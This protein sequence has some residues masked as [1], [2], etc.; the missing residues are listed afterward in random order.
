MI[1]NIIKKAL[2]LLALII[3]LDFF[4]F[5]LW[6]LS[7]QKPVDSFHAGIITSTILKAIL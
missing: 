6:F 3:M 2:F 4:C 7:D 5:S 1:Y